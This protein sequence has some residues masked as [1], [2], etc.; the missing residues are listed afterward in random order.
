MTIKKKN[1][2]TRPHKTKFK[3]VHKGKISFIEWKKTATNLYYG[4]YGLKVLKS[5]RIDIRQLEA[6]RRLI[7]R[8]LRKYEFLWI[9]VTPDIP[10]TAKPNEVRMGK[11]KGA[12]DYWIARI[13]AGQT[14]FELTCML[15]KKAYIILMSAAKKLPVPCVFI[16]SKK[17]YW[18]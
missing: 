4:L 16:S 13:K 9:R 10:V 3:K 7:S 2:I 6:A 1:S 15:P 12:V 8:P 5:C 17:K 14:L 11:G 18:A